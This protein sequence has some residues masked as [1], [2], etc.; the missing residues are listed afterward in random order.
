M[1]LISDTE[2][3][4]WFSFVFDITV[5]V[6]LGDE[7]LYICEA[8]NSFGTIK[9]GVRVS[10]SGLGKFLSTSSLRNFETPQLPVS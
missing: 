6:W 2:T 1:L 3:A 10:V 4:L 8:K 7:G 9:T 5:G